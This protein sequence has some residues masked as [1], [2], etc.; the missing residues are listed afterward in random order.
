MV[1]YVYRAPKRLASATVVSG[2]RRE[3]LGLHENGA[4][5]MAPLRDKSWDNDALVVYEFADAKAAGVTLADGQ[6]LAPAVAEPA[7]GGDPCRV[8]VVL[9]QGVYHQIKRMFGVFDVGVNGLHRSNIGGVELDP[10]LAP[11]QYRELTGEEL[12]R[13]RAAAGK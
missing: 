9:R 13:L 4:A 12:S 10:A 8:H 6:T 2:T 11:G 5:Y 7:P 1:G 3:A